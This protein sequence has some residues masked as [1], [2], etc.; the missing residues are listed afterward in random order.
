MR[1]KAATPRGHCRRTDRLHGADPRVRAAG[2][3]RAGARLGLLADAPLLSRHPRALRRR[4]DV[5]RP[6]HRRAGTR[7]VEALFRP[8]TRVLFLESPGSLTFEMQDV[9]LLAEVARARGAVSMIDNTWATPLYFQPLKHGVD[10]SIHAATST[11]AATPTSS[12]AR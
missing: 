9:P 5:L 8:T 1:S 2:R 7:A 6:A 11:S 12:W 3:P 4:D 10:I